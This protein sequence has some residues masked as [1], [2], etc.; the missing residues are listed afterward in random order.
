VQ[1]GTLEATFERSGRLGEW[2][3]QLLGHAAQLGALV[4]EA[5]RARATGCGLIQLT[6][7]RQRLA[8]HRF[9]ARL[10]Y[11]AS[12]IGMKKKL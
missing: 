9:Y 12:H 2:E 7:D 10:G 3:F 1:R 5:E 4:L 11:A 8:A 6:T